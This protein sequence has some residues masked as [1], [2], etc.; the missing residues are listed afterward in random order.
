M[1]S[2]VK[3]LYRRAGKEMAH[4]TRSRIYGT[5]PEKGWPYKKMK[6]HLEG[7]IELFAKEAKFQIS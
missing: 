1:P 5:P 7:L 2:W 3:N 6:S 4:L